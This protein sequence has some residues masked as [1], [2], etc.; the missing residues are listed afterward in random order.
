MTEECHQARTARNSGVW[1]WLPSWG[2]IGSRNAMASSYQ[3]VQIVLSW[4]YL[5]YLALPGPVTAKQ[6]TM[7]V[8]A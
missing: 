1:V 3:P 2:L 8:R 5:G 6:R 7:V 4:I